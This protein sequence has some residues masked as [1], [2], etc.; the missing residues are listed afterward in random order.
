[1]TIARSA[2]VLGGLALLCGPGIEGQVPEGPTAG[3]S[4]IALASRVIEPRQLGQG[5]TVTPVPETLDVATSPGG[6]DLVLVKFPGPVTTAELAALERRAERVYTYL[7]DDAFLIRMPAG[8]RHL[9]ADAELGLSWSGPYHP[10]Y[11]I[12]PAL[13]A[14]GGK[15]GSKA[16]SGDEIRS[17]LVHVYPDQHLDQVVA[18]IELMEQGEVVAAQW[19]ERF[20]RVRLLMTPAEIVAVR[21]RLAR[22]AE[23]F[24]IDLEPRRVLLND[25]TAW[26]AQSGTGGGRRTPIHDRGIRGQNQ[27]VAVLDTG[28]DPDMCYFRDP[29][30]GLPPRNLCNAGITVNHNQRKVIAVDFLWSGECAGGISANEW[31][32]HD[33]GTHVAGILAGDDFANPRIRDPGDGLAPGAKLVIQDGGAQTDNCADLPG[34]GCPVVD[35]N[36]IFLQ[37]FR[38]GA[39]IHSNSWGDDEN[40]PTG[41]LY[42]AGSEDADQFTWDH[43]D[44]LLVFAAGN[45]GPGAGTA[46]SPATAKN[47]VAAGATQRA[48]GAEQ[49]ASFSS[50]GPTADGRIKPDVT[51][52]GSGIVSADA[53]ND[54]ETFNC[55]VRSASGT[56][57]ATPG[58]AGALALIRQYYTAGWYPTGT[59][60]AADALTPSAAL[61]KATLINSGHDMTEAAAIPGAC[62]G[63]GRTLLDDTL[64]FDGQARQLWVEDDAGF[65]QGSSGERTFDF[66]IDQGSPLE[67]TLVWTDSPS[68]PAAARNLVNDLDLVVS[69]PGGTRLGNV[70][71]GGASAPGGN[72]DRLNNVEQ[73]LLPSPTAGAYT[74]TVRAFNV[75]RGP[76]PFA[77]VVTA[78]FS[79]CTDDADCDD[80]VFCNGA[81]TCDS[82]NC[83]AGSD[84]CPGQACEEAPQACVD[85]LI[86]ADCD[87][88]F[89]CTADACDAAANACTNT[90]D[91]ALCA[92]GLLCDGVETCD[93]ALGCLAGTPIDCG[94]PE[95]PASALCLGD[96]R[97]CVEALWSGVEGDSGRGNGNGLTSDS[98]TFWFFNQANV[99]LIVKVLDACVAPYDRFWVFAAGL[100]DVG[101]ELSVIDL[102]TGELAA[103]SNPAGNA[104]E[105]IQ[106][107]QAF[108]TCA[109]GL[110]SRS[111]PAPET[112]VRQLKGLLAEPRP[113]P[114]NPPVAPAL[115]GSETCTPGPRSL[116]LSDGRFRVEA[117][118]RTR[119]GL[120]GSGQAVELTGDTGYFWFFSPDNVEAV[121]KVLDACFAPFDRF[122]VFAAGLT[123]VEVTLKVTDT[124][125]GE[126]REYQNPQETAFRPIQDTQAF[127][128]CP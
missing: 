8:R 22:L 11:K 34:I 29:A 89:A 81:E 127:A 1:M 10:A 77:L 98:G 80:G 35:L 109:A 92:D 45:S 101:V 97:F 56:S 19:K 27:I 95:V 26:V 85:C 128:T 57:M 52:P 50:C 53:D 30:R 44:F 6:E 15:D 5:K 123:N 86:D 121:V 112:V 73:V 68:T 7:P 102:A 24:W 16:G 25:T 49:M 67:V 83:L 93:P 66:L 61:M 12:S 103:Y 99:E 4:T 82:G 41:G 13:A 120:E 91:D 36:P 110:A 75:P 111:V 58:V 78:R 23:V 119:T 43:K 100:T 90:P 59:A 39:R 87:D 63:W 79:E 51:M 40:N 20:S 88:G 105:P 64:H 71:A 17:V 2:A 96:D 65:A 114:G 9:L 38:Q 55:G 54:T 31:D 106:D 115:R 69:G 94:S 37:A 72:A 48:T 116:C 84:P 3:R 42:S 118:W 76:Q 125:S 117:R 60:R 113:V 122:W 21:D 33:H 28:I 108:A 18:R 126:V 74:V 14:V 62:Q 104:F 70:F 46:I 32:T 47:V 124:V 107:T